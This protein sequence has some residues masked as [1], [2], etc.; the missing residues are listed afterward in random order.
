MKNI[1][2]SLA[3]VGVGFLGG[4]LLRDAAPVDAQAGAWTPSLQGD[5]NGDGALTLTDPVLLLNFLFAG[6]AAPAPL[7]PAPPQDRQLLP[8]TGQK[9]CWSGIRGDNQD[10][11]PEP[12]EPDHGQD[13]YVSAG[14]DHDFELVKGD[15]NDPKT[16]ITIDHTM[17]FMWQ[18]TDDVQRRNWTDSLKYTEDLELGGFTDWRMPNLFELFTILNIGAV[19]PDTGQAFRTMV[20]QDF[21]SL[22][23]SAYWTSSTCIYDPSRAYSVQFQ[24]GLVGCPDK[25]GQGQGSTRL[26]TLAVRAME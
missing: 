25:G 26:L 2:L 20:Y 13:A 16:W 22:K 8:K 18:Y 12:G 1:A 23:T 21:Y 24:R 9:R 4:Y 10:P 11:C 17:G 6:G 14:F 3:L 15:E 19:N 7:P 5:A